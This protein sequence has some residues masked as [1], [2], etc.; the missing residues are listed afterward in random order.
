M[1][2]GVIT[3]QAVVHG[4]T[5]FEGWCAVQVKKLIGGIAVRPWKKYPTHSGVVEEGSFVAWPK[6]HLKKVFLNLAPNTTETRVLMS[7]ASSGLAIVTG[8]DP[9]SFRN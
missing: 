7:H 5:L 1:G 6:K 8:P 3:P 2:D 9:S 4:H